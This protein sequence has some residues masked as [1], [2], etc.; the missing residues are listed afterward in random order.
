MR[1]GHEDSSM[2]GQ[3]QILGPGGGNVTPSRYILTTTPGPTRIA[4]DWGNSYGDEDRQ[5]PSGSLDNSLLRGVSD[6]LL[7]H[8]HLDHAGGIPEAFCKGFKPVITTTEPCAGIVELLLEDAANI[9]S[10]KPEPA[11]V[12][13]D[14]DRALHNMCIVTQYQ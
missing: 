7:S 10:H 12:S 9:E 2:N 6:V 11:F 14:I 8:A 5:K 13:D 3:L 4:I 1:K